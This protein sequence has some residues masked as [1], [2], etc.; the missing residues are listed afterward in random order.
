MYVA[1]V[2]FRR[3]RFISVVDSI[4]LYLVSFPFCFLFMVRADSTVNVRE[5]GLRKLVGVLNFLWDIVS[6]VSTTFYFVRFLPVS[7]V[8]N[9]SFYG[10]N[11]FPLLDGRRRS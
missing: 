9:V 6:C 7:S 3:A 1:I 8:N 5:V 10:F 11:F 2:A 4:P